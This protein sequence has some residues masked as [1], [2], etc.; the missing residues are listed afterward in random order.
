MDRFNMTA[1]LAA[2]GKILMM[3]FN[4]VP[5]AKP[6]RVLSLPE[7]GTPGIFKIDPKDSH[8]RE[9]SLLF[10]CHPPAAMSLANRSPSP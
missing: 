8:I 6:P 2:G 10:L 5:G 1:A 3:T 4:G 7:R 9:G